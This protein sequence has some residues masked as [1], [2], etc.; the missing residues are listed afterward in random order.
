MLFPGFG[1]G[2]VDTGFIERNLNALVPDQEPDDALWRGA[3]AVA[4][5]VDEDEDP[6]ADLAGFRLNAAPNAIVVLGRGGEFR[7]IALDDDQPMAA[8]SGLRD[9]ERV[10]VFFEG[11]ATEFELT[12]RGSATGLGAA[13]A[14]SGVIVAPMPGRVTAVEVAAGDSVAKGQRVLTLEAMKMEHGLVAPFDGVVAELSAEAGAQ[15][16]EGAVLA[17]VEASAK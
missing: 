14:G 9:D 2:N 11:Q 4:T 13:A 12:S 7:S 3:A 6:L 17:R 15:V 10:V 8:V 5:E 1:T 16:S